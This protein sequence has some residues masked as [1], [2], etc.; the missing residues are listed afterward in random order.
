MSVVP[1]G[2]LLR[3]NGEV[4][5]VV[6]GERQRISDPEAL[7]ELE[8]GGEAG[9]EASEATPGG[10][11]VLTLPA[12]E[13]E[14]IPQ[15]LDFEIQGLVQQYTET[16]VVSDSPRRYMA[17]DARVSQE[18]GRI[19]ATTRTWTRQPWWGFTGGVC[20]LLGRAD[21]EFVHNTDLHW[22][23]GVDG[24]RIGRWTRQDYWTQ[25]IPVDMSRQVQSMEIVH[26]HAP[27]NRFFERLEEIKRA[28]TLIADI[29]DQARRIFAK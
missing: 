1:D 20:V 7:N 9:V 10:S 2:T 27:K 17:T 6:A 29:A 21:G 22:P 19:D 8:P 26:V 15:G 4:F 12:E 25:Y 5:V 13:I 14:R 11:G 24:F 3:A 28:A 23:L 18:N 16:E